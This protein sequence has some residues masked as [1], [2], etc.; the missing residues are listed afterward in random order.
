M[1]KR[2]HGEEVYKA[3]DELVIIDVDRGSV[4]WKEREGKSQFNSA[5]AGKE[6]GFVSMNNGREYHLIQF[7][8][9]GRTVTLKRSNVIW[10]KHTG[11]VPSGVID[12][13]FHNTLDDSIK[14]LRDVT[15]QENG[16]NR[17]RTKGRNLPTG[18]I[19]RNNRYRTIVMVLGKALC[20]GTYG[21]VEEAEAVVIQKRKEL[22]FDDNHGS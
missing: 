8:Y 6:A 7:I 2:I 11:K 17:K 3:L 16:K 21:T 10:W 19:C 5:W 20:L 13:K 18:V 1:C 12:H 4:V 22:G 9:N 14:G 15:N